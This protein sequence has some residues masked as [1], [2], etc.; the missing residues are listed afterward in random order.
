MSV[1]PTK[2]V[3]YVPIQLETGHPSTSTPNVLPVKPPNRYRLVSDISGDANKNGST[4]LLKPKVA[5]PVRQ[6]V[7]AVIDDDDDEEENPKVNYKR[8][9]TSYIL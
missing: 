8:N 9:L 3:R 1:K 6:V 7:Q 2:N 4:Y 5:S